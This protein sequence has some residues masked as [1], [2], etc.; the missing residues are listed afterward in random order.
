MNTAQTWLLLTSKGEEKRMMRS[1]RLLTLV[2]LC[3]AGALL[4]RAATPVGMAAA[5]SGVDNDVHAAL[6]KLYA[7]GLCDSNCAKMVVKQSESYRVE[8][9]FRLPSPRTT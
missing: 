5:A 8:A 9:L 6:R 4:S 7:S 3:A 1:M 2:L